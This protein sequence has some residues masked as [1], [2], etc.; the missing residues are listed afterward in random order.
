MKYSDRLVEKIVKLIEQDSYTITE[1]CRTLKLT[2]KTFYDWKKTRSDFRRAIEEA[3]DRRD[4]ALATLVRH[5]LRD[6]LEGYIEVTER[7][8]YEDDGWG[9]EKIKN[10]VVTK[11]KRAPGAHVMKLV[12]DRQD[13]KREK[14]KETEQTSR[15]FVLKFPKDA[16]VEASTQMVNKFLDKVTSPQPHEIRQQDNGETDDDDRYTTVIL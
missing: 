14:Q 4:E 16:D 5:S 3:E 1:I 15:P 13:K 12:L 10:R 8:T 11:R 6:Q 9:G 2:T 7:I